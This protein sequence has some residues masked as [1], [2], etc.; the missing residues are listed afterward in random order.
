M[1]PSIY[2]S[3]QPLSWSLGGSLAEFFMVQAAISKSPGVQV[4]NG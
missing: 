4:G 1:P 2:R 3:N